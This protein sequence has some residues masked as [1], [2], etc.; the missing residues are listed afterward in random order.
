MSS[1]YARCSGHIFQVLDEA[2]HLSHLGTTGSPIADV[3]AR[4]V[5]GRIGPIAGVA[6]MFHILSELRIL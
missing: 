5:L 6:T 1:E 4:P 3:F 2:A